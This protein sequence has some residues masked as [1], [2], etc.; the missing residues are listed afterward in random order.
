M[1]ELQRK[2]AEHGFESNDDYEYPVQVMLQQ[3]ADRIRCLMVEGPSE[4]RKTAFANALAN[5]LDFPKILYH[6]FTQQHPPQPEM[7]LPPSQDELGRS[8]TPV[9]AIDQVISEAC[10]F[11]EGTDTILILDQ[12][13]AADFREHLRLYHFLQNAQWSY[14]DACYYANPQYLVVVLI[15]EEPLFHSLQK[16]S[17]RVWVSATSENMPLFKPQDFGLQDDAA[18]MM[19]QLASLFEALGSTPTRSEYAHILHDIHQ[20]ARTVRALCHSLYGWTEGIAHEH[21]ISK[22]IQPELRKTMQAIEEYLSEDAIEI[23]EIPLPK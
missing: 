12:L 22:K 21:L 3:N 17:F 19:A 8:E 14:R 4:R 23:G 6:D 7:T 1:S 10:A 9:E 20:H 16:C 13:Q 5:A 18:P 15:S 11:S 2:M